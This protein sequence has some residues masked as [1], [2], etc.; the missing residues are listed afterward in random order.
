METTIVT[1]PSISEAQM[2]DYEL[3]SQAEWIT[4]RN[5]ISNSDLTRLAV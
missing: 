4:P 3:P 2:F 1:G 5:R